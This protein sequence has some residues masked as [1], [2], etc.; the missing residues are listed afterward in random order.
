MGDG[1]SKTETKAENTDP[2]APQQPYLLDAFKNAQGAYDTNTAQGAYGGDYV[3]A[4]HRPSTT[5]TVTQ[6]PR[7]TTTRRLTTAS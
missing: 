5:P 3:A 1:P 2:W 7:A 6:S 4:P